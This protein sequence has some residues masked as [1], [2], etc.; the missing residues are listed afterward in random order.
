MADVMRARSLI[1]PCIIDGGLKYISFSSE[2]GEGLMEAGKAFFSKCQAYAGKQIVMG[3]VY[4]GL[5]R[6]AAIKAAMEVANEF[7]VK[8][9]YTTPV[10][11]EE[12]DDDGG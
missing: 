8:V 3:D 1:V 5:W 9:N 7:G 6:R 11:E 10:F 2:T 4:P 12:G